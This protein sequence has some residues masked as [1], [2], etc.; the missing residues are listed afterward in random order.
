MQVVHDEISLEL[1]VK[2][3]IIA[4]N[5]INELIRLS[6]DHL[7]YESISSV[8]EDKSGNEQAQLKITSHAHSGYEFV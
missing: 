7:S 8:L 6:S 1:T 2:P 5:S 4:E 3:I